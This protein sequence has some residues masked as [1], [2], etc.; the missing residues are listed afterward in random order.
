MVASIF[1]PLALGLQAE[2]DMLILQG[3]RCCGWQWGC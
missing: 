1:S 2:C 3:S